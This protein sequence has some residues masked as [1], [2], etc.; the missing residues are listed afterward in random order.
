M[1]AEVSDKIAPAG[2]YWV[3]HAAAALMVGILA[4]RATPRSVVLIT[5]ATGAWAALFTWL[6][7]VDDPLQPEVLAE[8]GWGYVGQQ[9]FAVV[10]PLAAVPIT[11]VARW[12]TVAHNSLRPD[13]CAAC[14]YDLRATPGRCPE[15]GTV[16]EKTF[17]S[18]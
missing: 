15:C 14:G 18:N 7:V 11:R 9:T 6:A 4:W 13:L 12:Y 8:L 2:I 5:V 1:L 17:I 16:S 10:L 3:I